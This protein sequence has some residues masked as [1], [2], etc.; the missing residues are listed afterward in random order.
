[1]SSEMGLV[2]LEA[3]PV[4]HGMTAMMALIASWA[5]DGLSRF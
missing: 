2:E 3:G 4:G 5:G 1:M